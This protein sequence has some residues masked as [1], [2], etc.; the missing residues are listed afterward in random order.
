MGEEVG[1]TT[2]HVVPL[3]DHVHHAVPGGT[4]THHED[5]GW[6]V[7]E[8]AT[9]W[10]EDDCVCGPDLE[11]VP[12]PHGPDGWLVTHHSLDGQGAQAVGHHLPHAPL[13]AGPGPLV[14]DHQCG[15]SS[16]LTS[17]NAL[18]HDRRSTL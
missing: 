18:E 6:L 7:V 14:V 9:T 1:V 17:T 8:T 11:H 5:S 16:A 10:H 2:V 12:N 3:A 13:W 4:P 15:S